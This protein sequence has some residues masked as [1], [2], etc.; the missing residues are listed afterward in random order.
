MSNF[1]LVF[2]VINAFN[3]D[4]NSSA[5]CDRVTSK[6]TPLITA[7]VDIIMYPFSTLFLLTL[8]RN[9]PAK[10]TLV[11]SNG[12]LTFVRNVGKG[13]VDCPL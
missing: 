8:Y 10:S 11:V 5:V 1:G 6:C 9:G 12:Q 2:R 4:L 13:A 3:F 7:H